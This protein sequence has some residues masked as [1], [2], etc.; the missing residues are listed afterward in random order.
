[1]YGVLRIPL[2]LLSLMQLCLLLLTIIEPPHGITATASVPSYSYSI[3]I[4][5]A[6]ATSLLLVL[7]TALA[8]VGDTEAFSWWKR[9]YPDKRSQYPRG[10]ENLTAP[11]RSR[12]SASCKEDMRVVKL[13][14]RSR[15]SF[16]PQFLHPRFAHGYSNVDLRVRTTDVDTEEV[17]LDFDAKNRPSDLYTDTST[18]YSNNTSIGSISSETAQVESESDENTITSPNKNSTSSKSTT[19]LYTFHYPPTNVTLHGMSILLPQFKSWVLY[20]LQNENSS[21]DIVD[22]YISSK[23]IKIADPNVRSDLRDMWYS[24]KLICDRTEVLA[25]YPSE[26]SNHGEEGSKS[27][28]DNAQKVTAKNGEGAK[29]NCKRGGFEDLLTVY[30]D[31]ILG[32]M[33]DEMNDGNQGATSKLARTSSFH[34]KT[35]LEQNYGKRRTDKLLIQNFEKF[36][37]DRQKNVFLHLLHWFKENYPYYYDQCGECGA[38][39]R[40]DSEKNDVGCGNEEGKEEN[41]ESNDQL[42]ESDSSLVGS[43]LGYCY[44]DEHE[45]EGRAARTEI[46]Q[47]HSCG[48]YTRF[49]RY[50]NVKHI[51]ENGGRGRCGEYSIVLYRILR[52]LGHQARWVVDWADH[53]WAEVYFDGRWVHMDPCEAALDHPLLYKEWGKTQTY[54]VAFWIPLKMD[55]IDMAKVSNENEESSSQSRLTLPFPFIQDVTEKYTSDSLDEISKRRHEKSNDV[56]IRARQKLIGRFN[57]INL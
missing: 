4:R 49:P 34:M 24:R 23:Q 2:Q 54:I 17:E 46:Y 12:N 50:N 53:V 20:K 26:K 43:F 32:I 6:P 7:T 18:S 10:Q 57:K 19:I 48:K 9:F 55:K 56:I 41:I 25:V 1:M 42:N 31:R 22:N 40:E 14:N 38:S 5:S 27:C 13:N 37:L 45:L 16:A 51:V 39:Y 44:P 29:K 11:G 21:L 35:W 47:C 28:V 3:T 33:K 15:L 52:A 30:C 8:S 36:P